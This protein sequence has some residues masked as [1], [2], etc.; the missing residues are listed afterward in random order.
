MNKYTHIC[1][2]YYSGIPFR[3]PA[4]AR[5]MSVSMSGKTAPASSP[6]R[7]SPPAISVTDPT[8]LG[9]TDPPMSPAIAR[10]ANIAVPPAGI[11][12]DSM[13]MVP[14]HMIP[15]ENPHMM[16]PMSPTSGF[17]DTEAIR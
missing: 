16:H 8:M 3:F 4:P 17:R 7:R 6:G 13:L 12:F 5:T 11:F 9:P 1:G 15:T 2:Q 14:G 10:R